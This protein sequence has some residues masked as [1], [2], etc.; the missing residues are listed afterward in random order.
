[1][2]LRFS[3]WYIPCEVRLVVGKVLNLAHFPAKFVRSS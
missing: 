1:L 3:Q 2:P